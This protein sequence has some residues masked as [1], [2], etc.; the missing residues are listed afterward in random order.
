MADKKIT[1]SEIVKKINEDSKANTKYNS[2]HYKTILNK[3]FM[4][5]EMSKQKIIKSKFDAEKTDMIDDKGI[6]NLNKNQFTRNAFISLKLF[7]RDILKKTLY[8][9]PLLMLLSGLLVSVYGGYGL[10]S[11]LAHDPYGIQVNT[12]L[13]AFLGIVAC[14]S[15]PALIVGWGFLP[16]YI[17]NKRNNNTFS[18]LRLNGFTKKQFLVFFFAWTFLLL[19]IVQMFLWQVWV[20]L[21]SLIVAGSNME[22]EVVNITHPYVMLLIFQIILF[23]TMIVLTGMVI[24]FIFKNP[25]VFMS[26]FA[27]SLL[28]L[29]LYINVLTTDGFTSIPVHMTWEWGNHLLD[30]IIFIVV[31][32]PFN[33][34]QHALVLSIHDV[35]NFIDYS[36]SYFDGEGWMSAYWV[37]CTKEFFTWSEVLSSTFNVTTIALIITFRNKIITFK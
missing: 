21:F 30:T 10:D 33:F 25:R 19:L 11:D 12:N 20:P 32:F 6:D 15:F 22:S 8:T 24:G 36:G 16:N 29:L 35:N 34:I 9:L 18:R 3:A 7:S 4:S 28:F 1:S 37:A 27:V 31:L 13:I 26:V 14:F 17:I 23:N 5:D 2:D